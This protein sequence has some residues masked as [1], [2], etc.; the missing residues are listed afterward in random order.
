[1]QVVRRHS[2]KSRLLKAILTLCFLTVSSAG[3]KSALGVTA[4]SLS[5]PFSKLPTSL[6]QRVYFWENI[7]LKYNS[8]THVIHDIKEPWLVIDILP[9]EK[10]AKTNDKEDLLKKDE[11]RKLT[12]KYVERYRLA[13][14]RFS[15]EG[16][17][18]TRYGAMEKRIHKVYSQRIS[19][20]KRLYKG[21]TR[22]RY[23]QGL[24]DTFMEASKRAQKYL[25][26]VEREFRS[27]GIP[28][29]ISRLAFVESMFN[30]AAVSKVGA[31][32]MWQFM[33]GTAKSYMK[34]N[35]MIDERNS[36]IKAAR[37][38]ARLLRDN[39][40]SLKSWPLAITAYNHGR[41]GMKRAVK[42]TKTTDLAKII[43]TY[44][45]ATF[46]FASQ[47]FYAEFLAAL[48]S[49]NHLITSGIIEIEP[50]PMDIIS[51]KLKKP[52]KVSNLGKKLGIPLTDLQRLNLCIKK[53]TFERK[54]YYKL[55]KNYEIFIPRKYSGRINYNIASQSQTR[56][57]G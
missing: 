40:A 8:N 46:G 25:P 13:L 28:V 1:M 7:F 36:P 19:S 27:V 10:L 11:Q 3:P 4:D 20:L 12:R 54:A 21:D 32:G 23:Q 35:N 53:S 14:Q 42:K 41:A 29:E 51:L 34:V 6:S 56:L 24:S 44:K 31:S 33:K 52:I 43:K 55:P 18:A 37:A 9:F 47:N 26:Y 2:K 17:K 22:I 16:G 30:S 39:Y 50:S 38:A 57:R 48:R 45:K 49:Y 5:G 15:K